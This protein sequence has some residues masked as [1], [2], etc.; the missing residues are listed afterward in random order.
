M[1]VHIYFTGVIKAMMTNTEKEINFNSAAAWLGKEVLSM[2]SCVSN[3]TRFCA[4]EIRLRAGSPLCIVTPTNTYFLDKDLRETTHYDGHCMKTSQ[5]MVQGAFNSICA[6]SVHSHQQEPENGYITVKGGHRAGICGTAVIR[7][8]KVTGVRNITSINMRIAREVL[9]ASREI[10][11][12]CFVKGVT[13]L[14]VAGAPSS[15]KTTVLRDLARVLSSEPH[16]L[17]TA[18]VDERGEIGGI[19]RGERCTNLGL[20]CDL[21]DAY[22]KPVGIHIAVRVLSPDL[23]IFDEA[24]TVE[25]CRAISE[26]TSSGVTFISSVHAGSFEELV[27]RKQVRLLLE[28]GAFETVVLLKGRQTPGKIKAVYS[29]EEVLKGEAFGGADD[30]SCRDTC[31]TF[32]DF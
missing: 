21:L 14:L 6:Y 25:E 9:G 15:G 13:G 1:F 20:C 2:L 29:A 11:E 16:T 4:Q 27:R 24:G 32:N 26:G 3:E 12:K 17:K 8:G 22:P 28:T 30:C 31:R 7:D 10:T 23:I 18:V 5:D 19:Y